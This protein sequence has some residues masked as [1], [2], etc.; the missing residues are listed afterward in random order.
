MDRFARRATIPPISVQFCMVEKIR[1]RSVE[2]SNYQPKKP[3]KR[4]RPERDSNPRQTVLQTV[5]KTRSV[6]LIPFK[7]HR[8]MRGIIA[9]NKENASC[10]LHR[11]PPYFARMSHPDWLGELKKKDELRRASH[12]LYAGKDG[13]YKSVG[14]KKRYIAKPMTLDEVIEI[15]PGRVADFSTDSVIV[16]AKKLS[17]NTTTIGEL[18]DYFLER[19]WERYQ[20]GIPRRLDRR[21]YDDYLDVLIRFRESVGKNKLATSVNADWFTDYAK[22][23]AGKAASSVRREVI[24]ITRFFN[25]AGPGRYNFGFYSKV[26]DFSPEFMKPNDSTFQLEMAAKSTH[27]T[28]EQFKKA[29]RLVAPSPLLSAVGFLALNCAFLPVDLVEINLNNIDIEKR[30]HNFPRGK[31]LRQR[32]AVLMPETIAAIKRYLEYRKSDSEKLFVNERFGTPFS[33]R[34]SDDAGSR[35][36]HNNAISSY[37]SAIT[38]LQ[39]KGLRTTVATEL[40]GAVDQTALDIVMGHRLKGVRPVHYVKHF[41]SERLRDLL[42]PFWRRYIDPRFR[43]G[44]E[45]VAAFA[46]A[47]RVSPKFDSYA[48]SRWKKRG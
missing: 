2:M 26:V 38:G 32:R 17:A 40:D 33:M 36:G 37:W 30:E 14:G 15:L 8:W 7:F 3:K 34:R 42:S 24:Y 29:M 16:V 25:W 9:Q 18:I 1:A 35:V 13:W 4:K 31:T 5:P 22:T 47:C 11:L 28:P 41:S 21:T 43:V 19:M 20:T 27:I 10:I 46:L 12:G 48:K 44:N 45:Q 23:F 39:L 6:N